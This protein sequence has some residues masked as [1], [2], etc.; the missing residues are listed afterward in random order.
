MS[1]FGE[2]EARYGALSRLVKNARVLDLSDHGDARCIDT[3]L[4]AGARSVTISGP[5]A[6]REQLTAPNP[7]VMLTPPIELPLQF[8][9]SSFDVVI[10]FD[11]VSR[12]VRDSAWGKAVREVLDVDG[13]VVIASVSADGATR[14]LGPTFGVATVFAQAPL[15]GHM[16]YDIEAEELEPELDRTWADNG[17]DDPIRYVV[18]FA[19]DKHHSDT[20]TLVQMPFA[21]WET[22]SH[23]EL[24]RIKNERDAL[25]EELERYRHDRASLEAQITD[26]LHE[27]STFSELRMEWLT[28]LGAVEHELATE[29]AR[30]AELMEQN[31]KSLEEL[32]ASATAGGASNASARVQDD[33]PP[34]G[35]TIDGKS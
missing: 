26:L 12:L 21:R 3:L 28:R 10:C 14:V 2:T 4:T 18:V 5:D 8:A 25:A 27:S 34:G 20:L 32:V 35:D 17:I 1:L 22:T 6:L 23:G 29:R 13:A 24:E 11:L 30:V 16:L 31:A 33:F 7:D 15:V 9:P 19:P